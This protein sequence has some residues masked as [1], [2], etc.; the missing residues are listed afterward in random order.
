MLLITLNFFLTTILSDN[1]SF[2]ILYIQIG[3]EII[4]LHVPITPFEM[5]MSSL[6]MNKI[7]NRKYSNLN[8]SIEYYE[9]TKILKNSSINFDKICEL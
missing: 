9:K 7:I 8:V 4:K 3:D 2:I 5:K 1:I 6:T